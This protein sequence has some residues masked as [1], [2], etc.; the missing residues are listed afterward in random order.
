MG[1][2]KEISVCNTCLTYIATGELPGLS[3]GEKYA[4]KTRMRR[5]L[6]EQLDRVVATCTDDCDGDFS[7]TAC[8]CC[9]ATKPGARHFAVILPE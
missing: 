5:K 9:G 8:E 1:E 3:W 6:G 4:I 7:A 2:N